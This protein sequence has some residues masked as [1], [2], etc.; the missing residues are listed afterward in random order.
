MT[1]VH[2]GSIHRPD[3]VGGASGAADRLLGAVRQPRQVAPAA[4]A[5]ALRRE[6]DA[7]RAALVAVRDEERRRLRRDLHD[8]LGPAL[9][10]LALGL[11]TACLLPAGCRQQEE[12]LSSLLAETRGAVTDIR[13]IVYGLRPAAL[14]ELGLAGALRAEVAR[15]ERQPGGLSI[16]LHI[17][18]G[19]LDGL[20]AA[21]EEAVYRIVAEAVTNVL[22]HARARRCQIRIQPG[23]DLKLEVCDD[24]AGLPENWRPGVGITG[25]RER[26]AELGGELTIE[27]GSPRGTRV[28]ARL[29]V[30]RPQ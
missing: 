5:A 10:A 2:E 14:D 25:M 26:A 7:S 8:G 21:V 22:R 11:E 16:A 13:R 18:G 28:T 23:H 6:L 24:G 30:R 20:P 4:P 19:Q 29:P 17:L 15:L 1:S 12:L 27:P 9:A 3:R